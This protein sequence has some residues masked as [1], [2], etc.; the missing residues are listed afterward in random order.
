MLPRTYQRWLG[1]LLAEGIPEEKLATC[2]TCAMAAP[3]GTPQTTSALVDYFGANKCCTYFP[4]LP[5]FQVGGIL[6]DEGIPEGAQRVAAIIRGGSGVDPLAVRP[7]RKRYELYRIGVRAGFGRAEAFKC[8]YFMQDRAGGCSIWPYREAVCSTYFCKL[9]RPVKGGEFWDQLKG[10]ITQLEQTV[11]MHCAIELGI[12]ASII[13]Q[14]MV[15]PSSGLK[16]AADVDG[17]VD[18]ELQAKWWGTWL[19]REEAYYIEC[20]RR[21]EQLDLAAIEKLGGLTLARKLAATRKALAAL[22][23]TELPERL[24]VAAMLQV[25]PAKPGTI[26]LLAG[27]NQPIEMPAPV[28]ELLSYFQ[29]QPVHEVKA[30]LAEAGFD[31][32]PGFIEELWHYGFLVEATEPS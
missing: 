22:L 29:G 26:R 14:L 20:A 2:D 7:N 27:P 16:S 19:G 31:I 23:V 30:K 3:A 6:R 25:A 11:A 4:T 32:E 8:P 10:T 13:D 28:I 1:D 15:E 21:A 24:R 9:E 18:H 12:P 17:E 5:N